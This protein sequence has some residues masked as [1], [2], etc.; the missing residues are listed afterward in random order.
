MDDVLLVAIP[1]IAVIVYLVLK[2]KE[3]SKKKSSESTDVRGPSV[4]G[5]IFQTEKEEEPINDETVSLYLRENNTNRYLGRDGSTKNITMHEQMDATKQNSQWTLETHSD[6]TQ[7]L[8]I[9]GLYLYVNSDD[10]LVLIENKH[11][12]QSFLE[13]KNKPF[14]PS[15]SN[16]FFKGPTNQVSKND[17]EALTFVAE[18]VIYNDYPSMKWDNNTLEAI[19]IDNNSKLCTFPIDQTLDDMIPNKLNLIGVIDSRVPG[20]I[21]CI[22]SVQG[23]PIISKQFKVLQASDEDYEWVSPDEETR[24]KHLLAYL[25]YNGTLT[26]PCKVE[27]EDKVTYGTEIQQ[28]ND[29]M[30]QYITDAGVGSST[31][32][33]KV[34]SAKTPPIITSG[35]NPPNDIIVRKNDSDKPL[36]YRLMSSE[37]KC[38]NH[39]LDVVDCNHMDDKKFYIH[40]CEGSTFTDGNRVCKSNDGSFTIHNGIE[41][42]DECIQRIPR[43]P[44]GTCRKCDDGYGCFRIKNAND[45]HGGPTGDDRNRCNER[46]ED[47]DEDWDFDWL[48]KGDMRTYQKAIFENDYGGVAPWNFGSSECERFV[49]NDSGEVVTKDAIHHFYTHSCGNT[50]DFGAAPRTIR[51]DSE[52]KISWDDDNNQSQRAKIFHN[53]AEPYVEITDYDPDDYL[54]ATTDTDGQTENICWDDYD[55]VYHDTNCKSPLYRMRLDKGVWNW[56][57]DK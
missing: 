29:F 37:G 43:E 33:Y 13:S 56:N 32:N 9:G 2:M 45:K 39:A 52:A 17:A 50:E 57:F 34:L 22:S 15:F 30:C 4:N 8:K 42:S 5:N 49:V 25:N 1:F 26:A 20:T 12:F 36:P 24:E 14:K 47:S 23:V 27:E 6:N 10:K 16:Y 7:S 18:D 41:S 48:C 44:S 28:N 21:S 19:N 54:F 53:P 35:A 40:G 55:K 51:M 38:L 46:D 31:N 11:P 3:K